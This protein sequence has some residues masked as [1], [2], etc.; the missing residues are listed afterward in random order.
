MRV[1]N[2]VNIFL[3]FFVS[4]VVSGKGI[5]KEELG[6]NPSSISK[7]SRIR[8]AL[9]W[10]AEPQFGGFY[11]TRI[12]GI[13]E[14]NGFQFQIFPGGSGT[15]V[16]QMVAAKQFDFG[17][18]SGDELVVARSKG[19]DLVAIFATFQTNPQIIMTHAERGFNSLAD[20]FRNPGTLA[21]QKGLPYAQFL[22]SKYLKET[23]V[24]MVPYLGGISNFLAQ[25]N[26]SQQG[27]ISSEPLLAK[28][29]GASV[30]VFSVAES[31]F[32]PYT[33]VLITRR[34]FA[35]T[36]K[37]LVKSVVAAVHSGWVQYVSVP[38]VQEK[39]NREMS[40]L[41]PSIDI[42]MMK[43]MAIAQKEYVWPKDFKE[44]Q[45]GTMTSKRWKQLEDQLLLLK[46]TDRRPSSENYYVE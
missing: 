40:R 2:I 9:N 33:T 43:E 36:H 1:F 18:V 46:V 20:I 35:K 25:K 5:A 3:I 37:D 4:F 19:M 15:P 42:G 14:K 6:T 41:N 45:L 31:G 22:I 13:D 24:S 17:L 27:F 32:N 29:Q 12:A 28:K 39:T 34:E 38:E 30:K 44:D 26:H 8:L 7:I 21:L 16:V 23:K 10:K 11:T